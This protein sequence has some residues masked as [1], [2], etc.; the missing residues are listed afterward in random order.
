MPLHEFV[1]LDCGGRPFTVLVGVV[2]S[3]TPPSCPRCQGTRLRKKISR[4]ARL[5]SGDDAL[6]ALAES[7]DQLDENDPRAVR[8]FLREM[9][10]GMEDDDL[11]A[12]TLEALV[13]ESNQPDSGTPALEE[14]P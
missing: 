3:S 6:D 5:R 9:S 11:N 12:D 2:A 7:A 10:A 8:R 4:F 1:C 14:T 13:T